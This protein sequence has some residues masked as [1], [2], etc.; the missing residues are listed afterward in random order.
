M[1]KESEPTHCTGRRHN[2]GGAL[3]QSRHMVHREPLVP[4]FV[5]LCCVERLWSLRWRFGML[6]GVDNLSSDSFCTLWQ[7]A[8][9]DDPHRTSTQQAVHLP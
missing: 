8:H 2:L 7:G 5:T 9:L 3:S 1:R 6:E 4:I